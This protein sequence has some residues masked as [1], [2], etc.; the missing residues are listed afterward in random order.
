MPVT[1]SA[2]REFRDRTIATG[3]S[4][5]GKIG[6]VQDLATRRAKHVPNVIAA[7]HIVAAVGR[8]L[9]RFDT[10]GGSACVD[11]HI[12]RITGE[13][14]RR[15]GVRTKVARKR[16]TQCG[17]VQSSRPAKAGCAVA[18]EPIRAW[19]LV[20]HALEVWFA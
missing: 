15:G 6:T 11:H 20:A 7:Q 2:Q 18:I 16:G 17:A 14:A 13:A 19:N 9:E 10:S 8:D 1:R 5:D 12:A 4:L 3:S